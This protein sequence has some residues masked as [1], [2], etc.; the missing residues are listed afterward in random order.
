MEGKHSNS[1]ML[2]NHLD[3][4]Y[5]KRP[6]TQSLMQQPREAKTT[7]RVMGK[8]CV[9]GGFLYELT[10]LLENGDKGPDSSSLCITHKEPVPLTQLSSLQS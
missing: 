4:V 8:L 2:Q 6:L 9:H 10:G 1:K 3:V 7:L 5:C